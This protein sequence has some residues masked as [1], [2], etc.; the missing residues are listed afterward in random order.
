M[1]P[2]NIYMNALQEVMTNDIPAKSTIKPLE[3]L[4]IDLAAVTKRLQ[5]P[6][7]NLERLW[8]IEDRRALKKQI[9]ALKKQIAALK[10]QIAA[11]QSS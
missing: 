5:G 10:K 11:L 7:S 2:K 9:A 3:E 1:K 6:L 4:Q 8:F